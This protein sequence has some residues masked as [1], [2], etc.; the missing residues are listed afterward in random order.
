MRPA[1]RTLIF[2]FQFSIF[3][4][5]AVVVVGEYCVGDCAVTDELDGAVVVL[6]QL[7]RELGRVV[8]MH[9]AIDTHYTFHIRGDSANI[10]R[11]N[12]NRHMLIEFPQQVVELVLKFVINKVC[13]LVE[14][15]QA[16]VRNDSSAQK[17]TL[18]FAAR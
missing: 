12:H 18:Q 9:G 13:G 4:L 7:G 16:R 2:N 11:H 8:A 5:L 14:Y 3:N 6:Q 1:G 10:V 17:R 15:K